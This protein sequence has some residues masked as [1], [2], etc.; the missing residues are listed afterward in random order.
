MA[1]RRDRADPE[2]VL[3]DI[4]EIGVAQSAFDGGCIDGS[5]LDCPI[6]R[7]VGSLPNRPRWRCW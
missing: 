1:Q 7:G 5:H 2:G 4:D 6:A 3:E